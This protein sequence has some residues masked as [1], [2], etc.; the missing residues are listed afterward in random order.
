MSKFL[1]LNTIDAIKGFIVAILS[2]GLTA[3]YNLLTAG[4]VLTKE[5]LT[6]IAVAW[7]AAGIW[8]LIKNVFKNSEWEYLTP[9]HTPTDPI[10]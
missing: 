5:A 6:S 3:L 9:E 2:A 7:L 4:T 8:Y 10:I 1:D